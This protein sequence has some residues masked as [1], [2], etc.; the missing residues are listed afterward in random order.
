MCSKWAAALVFSIISLTIRAC[1]KNKVIQIW[2]DVT[3]YFWLF[4]FL[5]LTLYLCG[6]LGFWCCLFVNSGLGTGGSQRLS[7]NIS[8]PGK[9]LSRKSRRRA[10]TRNNPA[11][12]L[13]TGKPK[14]IMVLPTKHLETQSALSIRSHPQNPTHCVHSYSFR[15]KNRY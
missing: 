15:W 9:I 8:L 10:C 11:P 4:I 13:L 1:L 3:H 12:F 2:T 14:G 7:H 5:I 6:G